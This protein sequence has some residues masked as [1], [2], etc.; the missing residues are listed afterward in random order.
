[1]NIDGIQQAYQVNAARTA[2]STKPAAEQTSIA[3]TQSQQRTDVVDISPNAK[4][5]S[6]LQHNTKIYAA[7]YPE[8]TSAERIAVLREQ[9][10]NYACPVSGHAIAATIMNTVFGGEAVQ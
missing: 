9:Y 7:A 4:F 6:A 8:K 2:K 10:A 1:M 3:G 5:R